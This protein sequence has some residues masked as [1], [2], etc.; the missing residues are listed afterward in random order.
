MKR[1]LI[2]ESE[3]DTRRLGIELGENARPGD[4]FALSGDLGCGKTV[5]AKGIA[6]GLGIDDEV[7]SP[8][9]ALLEIY[10]SDPELYHFDLYRIETADE[11]DQLFFEEYW[12]GEGVSIIEWAERAGKRLPRGTTYITLRYL[13]ERRRS[14][15]I[16]QA[17]D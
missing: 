15:Q 7:T 5:L 11:L 4:V 14:I 12:E 13:D 1:E 6:L 9:F 2:S 17:T 3:D 8:T 10:R 16:E